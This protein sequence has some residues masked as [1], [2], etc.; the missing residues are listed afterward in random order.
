MINAKESKT[1]SG[2]FATPLK[3]V[4]WFVVLGFIVLA[5][6][7]PHWGTSSKNT[8]HEAA[9]ASTPAPASSD[10]DY[11]PA[12]FPAPKGD[13]EPVAPTF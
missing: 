6:E 11:F 1:G 4:A 2:R 8:Q 9:A 12:R 5:V 10:F 13:P 3:A 7:T